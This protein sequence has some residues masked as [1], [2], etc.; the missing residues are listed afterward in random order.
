MSE[1]ADAYWDTATMLADEKGYRDLSEVEL[2]RLGEKA[3]LDYAI[4]LAA[5]GMSVRKRHIRAMF[6]KLGEDY[7]IFV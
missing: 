6:D 4:A 5:K 3:F 7:V 1:P 2:T